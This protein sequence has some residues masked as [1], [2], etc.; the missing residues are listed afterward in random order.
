MKNWEQT[1]LAFLND[2]LSKNLVFP[3]QKLRSLNYIESAIKSS[4]PLLLKDKDLFKN[5]TENDFV[6]LYTSL[7]GRRI[8]R[9]DKSVIHGHCKFS[10]K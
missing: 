10:K 5:L 2:H 6:D 9:Y 8:N 1:K 7:K 3:D 4:C